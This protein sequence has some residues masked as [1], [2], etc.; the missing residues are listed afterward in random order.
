MIPP[1]AISL[2]VT[3]DKIYAMIPGT[4]ANA[5]TYFSWP[6]TEGG[7]S[8]ALKLLTDRRTEAPPKT[9]T[10]GPLTAA[11]RRTMNTYNALKRRGMVR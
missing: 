8:K 7:L 2:W 11:D 10:S 3:G 1:H 4:S 5:D 9:D 6:I